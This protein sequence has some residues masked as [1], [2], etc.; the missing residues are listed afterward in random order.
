MKW[1]SFF[2]TK[3]FVALH[4]FYTPILAHADAPPSY[5]MQ[6]P[7]A[8]MHDLP[9]GEQ[10][11]WSQPWWIN[12]EVSS[13]N[14]WNAPLIMNDLRNGKQYEYMADFEQA[15][16]I[17]EIGKSIGNNFSI[18]AEIPYAY[19]D[20][21]AM[22][23]AIDS[24]HVLIGNRRFNRQYYPKNQN[25]FFVITDGTDYFEDTSYKGGVANVSLK[26][27]YWILKWMGKQKD[28][29]PCGLAVST[30]TKFPL[31]NEKMGGTS[32]HV[33]QSLLLHLGAPIFSASSMWLTAGYTW[34]G[35][36]PAIKEWPRKNHIVMYE[37]NFDFSVAQKW[38]LI[39]S[40]RAESP[41]L[42]EDDLEYYDASSD[43]YVR[44]RNRSAS[45]WNSLVYWRG[46]QAI[47]LRYKTNAGNTWQFLIAEDWGI[48][49]F[50]SKDNF[51]SSGA[52]DVNFVLQTQF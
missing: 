31:Q 3:A 29:C 2:A 39:M 40:A 51:Y 22:D 4:I 27:K 32:G 19:R 18:A 8:W 52:P 10:P 42:N 11:G 34:L 24:F 46:T 41:F 16:A 20:G 6:H 25:I 43:P 37:L 30:Q 47:G 1:I 35:D 13:G 26:L 15:H 28:S 33:D 50:D 48:G 44:A 21:G 38:G 36:N 49:P 12:F 14:T 9:T 5:R 45:G 17:L 23:D 7:L